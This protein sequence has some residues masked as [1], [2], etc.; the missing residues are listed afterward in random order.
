MS[1]YERNTFNETQNAEGDILPAQTGSN[2]PNYKGPD[3]YT[4]DR[5]LRDMH[6]D[7]AGKPFDPSKLLEGRNPVTA[8]PSDPTITRKYVEG[9]ERILGRKETN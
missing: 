5:D 9:R 1:G 3:E 8:L 2:F 4:N 6:T 7:I